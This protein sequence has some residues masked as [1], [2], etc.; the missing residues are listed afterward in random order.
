MKPETRFRVNQVIP[1]LKE[2]KNTSYFPI[3]QLSILGDADFILCCNGG[4]VWLEL[5]DI[6]ESLRPLQEYKASW[7]VRTG[8]VAIKADPDNW[9]EVKLFLQQLNKGIL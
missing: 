6:K 3:Q 7:V 9:E 5:K 8:G 4:F 1:F 2:L